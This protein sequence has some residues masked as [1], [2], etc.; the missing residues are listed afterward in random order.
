MRC[1]AAQEPPNAVNENKNK[2]VCTPKRKQTKKESNSEKTGDKTPKK[3]AAHAKTRSTS[4]SPVAASS[5][6]SKRASTHRDERV[7]QMPDKTRP[8]VGKMKSFTGEEKVNDAETREPARTRRHRSDSSDESSS[9]ENNDPESLV[10]CR[11]KESAD[12]KDR[13][14]RSKLRSGTTGG[15]QQSRDK[16]GDEKENRVESKTDMKDDLKQDLEMASPTKPSLRSAAKRNPESPTMEG[17]TSAVEMVMG[18]PR[19]ASLRSVTKMIPAQESKKL[20]SPLTG[21]ESSAAEVEKGRCVTKMSHELKKLRSPST[22]K[23]SS[24]AEVEKGRCVTKMS[25]ALE[26]KKLRPLSMGNESS[27]AQVGKARCVTK[28]SPAQELKNSEPP[29]TAEISR[30]DIEEECRQELETTSPRRS[31]LRSAAK[32]SPAQ[33]LKNPELPT[34][35]EETSAVEEKLER[36]RCSRTTMQFSDDSTVVS[37]KKAIEISLS[38]VQVTVETALT[39][40]VARL[41]RSRVQSALAATTQSADDLKN[42]ANEEKP[43]IHEDKRRASSRLRAAEREKDISS[44]RG[45]TE[46]ADK[47][48]ATSQFLKCSSRGSEVVNDVKVQLSDCRRIVAG[49]NRPVLEIESDE[50]ETESI[51]LSNEESCS[52]CKEESTNNSFSKEE[53]G[54]I[55]STPTVDPC[56]SSPCSEKSGYSDEKRGYSL[57]KRAE[58]Q[59]DESTVSRRTRSSYRAL[60]EE[61]NNGSAG[62]RERRKTVPLPFTNVKSKS[63]KQ[64]CRSVRSRENNTPERKKLENR[65]AIKRPLSNSPRRKVPRLK[66]PSSESDSSAFSSSPLSGPICETRSTHALARSAVR[67][68][69][70]A[71]SDAEV[72]EAP[73]MLSETTASLG[74]L[75]TIA[76]CGT[77]RHVNPTDNN[78]V[79]NCSK[80]IET[81]LSGTELS[82]KRRLQ[83]VDYLT[84]DRKT[85]PRFARLFDSDNE[86]EDFYG[87]NVPQ[88]DGSFSSEGDL[89]Y[90]INSIVESMNNGDGSQDTIDDV[91][92]VTIQEGNTEGINNED[93]QEKNRKAIEIRETSR[94][95]QIYEKMAEKNNE[96]NKREVTRKRKSTSQSESPT[97][98]ANRVDSDCQ[99]VGRSLSDFYMKLSP[100]IDDRDEV[101]GDDDVFST[102]SDST[103]GEDEV[104]SP[105]SITSWRQKRK[106]EDIQ[107]EVD[108][109]AKRRKSHGQWSEQTI[110]E[111]SSQS[112]TSETPVKSGMDREIRARKENVNQIPTRFTSKLD[113]MLQE[114]N[115]NRVQSFSSIGDSCEFYDSDEP[116]YQTL[117]ER[118]KLRRLRN[119][120][121]NERGKLF[122]SESGHLC[123][124]IT[125]ED[126][127]F[128]KEKRWAPKGCFAIAAVKPII[129][130][131]HFA[132]K[133]VKN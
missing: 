56:P 47:S 30:S 76:V 5:T 3:C 39:D 119:I 18:S 41:T 46:G 62:G 28:I 13:V 52:P 128:K 127:N 126:Q 78:L 9:K 19:R 90:K 12:D 27:A 50:S 14:E 57:R 129:N 59:E 38:D 7:S 102:V 31:G 66:E 37:E 2:E 69:N 112:S 53:E 15:G 70:K 44:S 26:S 43:E 109:P 130:K 133:V 87:F 118:V 111:A 97:A 132:V 95:E 25:P 117:E 98:E 23:E 17:E 54:E 120:S 10:D 104:A 68:L 123:T 131:S 106:S 24:A 75:S 58:Q 83:S 110:T 121:Q 99:Y 103:D 36:N 122:F 22:G 65:R 16:N 33:E 4:S 105:F 81:S 124:G 35:D 93:V 116:V 89:S 8:E 80:G 45:D 67:S 21:K 63:P 71:D 72:A 20:R 73:S 49:R 113:E 125:S 82:K 11:V 94:Q 79:G 61:S 29:K 51:Q 74:D 55:S 32:T 84:K 92:N 88:F 42:I 96:I 108:R 114:E 40:H 107:P 6:R 64:R 60:H 100:V 34:V 86:E 101:D 85:E 48:D 1:A 91:E 77:P 115:R